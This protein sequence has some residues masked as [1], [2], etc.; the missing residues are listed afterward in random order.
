MA[1]HYSQEDRVAGLMSDVTVVGINFRFIIVMCLD[2]TKLKI[3][4]TFCSNE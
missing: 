3:H 1:K 4:L 2:F